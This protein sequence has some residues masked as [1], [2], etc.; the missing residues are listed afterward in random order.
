MRGRV[1]VSMCAACGG[2]I[3]WLL[4]LLCRCTAR[5]VLDDLGMHA[6]PP[7]L[8][9]SLCWLYLYTPAPVFTQASTLAVRVSRIEAAF[10]PS[11]LCHFVTQGLGLLLRI[12]VD[13]EH[14]TFI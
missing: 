12:L 9:I 10:S 8:C 14:H 13:N 6:R 5:H 2:A 4:S 3:L 11:S 1:S 7:A